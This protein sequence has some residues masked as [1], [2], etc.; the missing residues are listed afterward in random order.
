M[1]LQ[2]LQLHENSGSKAAKEPTVPCNLIHGASPRGL[3]HG[4]CRPP[5]VLRRE[6]NEPQSGAGGATTWE[7]PSCK[8]V[9]IR[10][11]KPVMV[12]PHRLQT[13]QPRAVCPRVGM[14]EHF[15]DPMGIWVAQGALV[16]ISRPRIPAGIRLVRF[17]PLVGIGNDNGSLH[18]G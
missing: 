8:N 16:T 5:R 1:S 14:D 7:L 2:P 3:W 6:E 11:Q 10:W 15:R 18:I 4:R 12:G 13:S 17:D 9:K